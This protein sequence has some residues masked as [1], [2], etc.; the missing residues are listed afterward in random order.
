MARTVAAAT[1][2]GVTPSAGGAPP[3]SEAGGRLRRRR[4]LRLRLRLLGGDHAVLRGVPPRRPAASAPRRRRASSACAGATCATAPSARQVVGQRVRDRLRVAELLAGAVERVVGARRVALGGG[5]QRGADLERQRLRHLDELGDVLLVPVAARVRDGAEQPLRLR[6]LGA[7]A[8]VLHLARR[9]REPPRPALQDLV[10]RVRLP[11]AD[12][13]QEDP[14]PAARSLSQ[15]GA[16]L[17]SVTRSSKSARSTVVATRSWS[18]VM[19]RRRFGFSA[20]QT[21]RNVSSAGFDA[22]PST[23]F[24]ANSARWSKRIWRPAIVAQK[25][26]SSSSRNLGS[27][28][29]HSRWI[30]ASRRATSGGD[31]DEPRRRR[32]AA[33]GAA[34][35]AAARRGAVT[36]APSR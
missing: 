34:L 17:T 2:A 12:R 19:R 20:A 7:R 21:A 27:I 5:E 25:R 23:N 13:A 32:E 35:H 4:P 24:F 29:C 14:H 33:A 26:C 11:L 9:A 15:G 3:S 30:T 36:R 28:R 10:G 22:R 31:R 18:A 1:Y 16:W 6:E 8:P